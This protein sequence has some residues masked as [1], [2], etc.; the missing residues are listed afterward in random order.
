MEE[1]TFWGL[2]T[3]DEEAEEVVA[4]STMWVLDTKSEK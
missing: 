4:V 2:T 3:R 1:E